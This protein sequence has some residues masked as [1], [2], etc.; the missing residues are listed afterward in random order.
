MEDVVLIAFSS[1]GTTLASGGRSQQGGTI[2]LYI[3]LWDA[4]TG[5]HRKTLMSYRNGSRDV[6]VVFSPDGKMVAGSWND[7]IS[8]WDANTGETLKTLTG[9]GRVVSIAFS[10]DNT[11]LVSAGYEINLWDAN[12][13]QHQKSFGGSAEF[14]AF[15]SDGTVLASGD[16]YN[17]INLWDVNTG[18]HLK[19]IT[20]YIDGVNC[21][22]FQQ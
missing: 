9:H 21:V 16:N 18:R 2:H 6:C 13:G 8:L 19:T 11:L 17:G 20:G 15:S 7:T 4:N 10:P 5:E 3:H 12:T 22:A 1:D 14:V